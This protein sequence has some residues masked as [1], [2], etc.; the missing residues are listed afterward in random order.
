M[1]NPSPGPVLEVGR[2]RDCRHRL[3]NPSL[4]AALLFSLFG[5]S[6]C[7]GIPPSVIEMEE[8]S[9]HIAGSALPEDLAP[10]EAFDLPEGAGVD[11]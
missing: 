8:E 2:G 9:H 3:L 7:L 5:L 11:K 10:A 6:G 4:P 1:R